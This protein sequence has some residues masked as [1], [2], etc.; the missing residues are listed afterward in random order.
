MLDIYEFEED[1]NVDKIDFSDLSDEER[2]AI[3]NMFHYI[4]NE[5]DEG[6]SE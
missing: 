6:V 1:E 5:G 4:E 3:F 2:F